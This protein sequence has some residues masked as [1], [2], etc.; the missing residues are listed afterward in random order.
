MDVI[1]LASQQLDSVS[2][3]PNTDVSSKPDAK[4]GKVVQR[5]YVMNDVGALKKKLKHESR[6]GNQHQRKRDLNL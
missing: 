1:S 4:K 3:N 2:L 5:N 6:K